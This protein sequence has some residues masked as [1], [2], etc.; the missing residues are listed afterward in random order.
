M[1]NAKKPDIVPVAYWGSEKPFLVE[2]TDQRASSGQVFI[3]VAVEN[4][5]PELQ[6]G[7]EVLSSPHSALAHK[8]FETAVGDKEALA[9]LCFSEGRAVLTAEYVS[10]GDNAL[11]A[12]FVRVDENACPEDVRRAAESFSSA[13]NGGVAG[14]YAAKLL[15][16]GFPIK[17][18]IVLGDAP[19]TGEAWSNYCLAENALAQKL[20]PWHEGTAVLGEGEVWYLTRDGDHRVLVRAEYVDGKPSN[21][22]SRFDIDLMWGDIT[23]DDLEAYRHRLE[24]ATETFTIVR[25][26]L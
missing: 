11:S 10:E 26:P 21:V 15:F 7:W 16:T 24:Q 13:V 4:G 3:D 8:W 9:Y 19:A 12:V 23:D 6:L 14:T 1:D 20:A 5:K 17:E 25:I 22:W 18:D 2:I